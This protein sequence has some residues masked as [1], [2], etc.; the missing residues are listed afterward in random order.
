MA[1][2]SLRTAATDP[3]CA[4]HR[5]APPPSKPFNLP[6]TVYSDS[7]QCDHGGSHRLVDLGSG[8]AGA[9]RPP[10]G[11]RSERFPC[12]PTQGPRW[13]EKSHA[14]SQT[15]AENKNDAPD[16]ETSYTP[17]RDTSP[18]RVMGSGVM[19]IPGL[20]PVFGDISD[21]IQLY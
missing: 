12:S 3:G 16:S 14:V 18:G 19:G 7:I 2:P 5:K 11:R 1:T 13:A 8:G 10:N 6:A 9:S 20:F 4:S 21:R 15:N 17:W